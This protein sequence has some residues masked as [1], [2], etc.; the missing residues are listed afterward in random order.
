MNALE[1]VPVL[2]MRQFTK[3]S[4]GLRA[5]TRDQMDRARSLTALFRKPSLVHERQESGATSDLGSGN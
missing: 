5:A 3:R 2:P 1:V 4:M